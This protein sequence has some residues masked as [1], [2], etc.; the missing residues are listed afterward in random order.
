MNNEKN[1]ENIVNEEIVS[2]ETVNEEVAAEEIVNDETVEEIVEEKAPKAQKSK[3]GRSAAQLRKLKYGGTATAITA[4]G[5]VVI[6]VINMI[7]T[8]L[9]DR[10]GLTLDMT[11]NSIFKLSEKSI[12][13]VEDI[14]K[15]INIY[16]LIDE[17]TYKAA[18]IYYSSAASVIESY[19]QINSNITVSYEDIISNPTFVSQFPHLTLNQSDIVVACGDRAIAL[20]QDD[21]ITASATESGSYTVSSTAEQSMTSAI[22]TVASDEIVKVSVL[23]GY[24]NGD[25]SGIVSLFTGN[26]YD[27][28]EVAIQTEEIDP[29]TDILVLY[30]IKRDL[31]EESIKKIE[32]FLK[33]DEKEECR[34]LYY[35]V[36]TDTSLED[37]DYF[38]AFLNDW[39]IDVSTDYIYETNSSKY[40]SGYPFNTVPEIINTDVSGGLENK[41]LY[42][43]M[44]NA[45]RVDLVDTGYSNEALL[46]FSDSAMAL[47]VEAAVEGQEI[48]TADTES[49]KGTA[50]VACTTYTQF[51]GTTPCRSR[52]V[53][54]SSDAAFSPSILNS[55][56]YGNADYLMSL[57]NVVTDN[58]TY[59]YVEA[60]NLDTATMVVTQGQVLG[61]MMAFII[62]VPLVVLVVGAIV[63]IR[64]R[65]R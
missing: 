56:Y 32:K 31:D 10:F 15:E 20:T 28:D 43:T 64:R 22:L 38:G 21:L 3:K 61:I 17:E 65:H 59:V 23:T 6:I 27:V 8:A 52:I 42:I 36:S 2:E 30:G 26:N 19:A 41:N 24:D 44:F 62:L 57:S 13:Y 16:I 49:A 60:K 50:A 51:D 45:R 29:E 4:I 53:V 40:L 63:W 33:N 37:M 12:Q 34:A 18:G 14:D 11:R 5:I 39:G 54:F 25:A 55:T 7:A 58:S 9:T 47:P 1:N 35:F 46:Q 48:S